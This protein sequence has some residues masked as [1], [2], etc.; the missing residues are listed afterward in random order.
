MSSSSVRCEFDDVLQLRNNP[1]V[2]LST[3]TQKKV[4]VGVRFELAILIDPSLGFPQGNAI[5]FFTTLA[6]FSRFTI[7]CRE[8]FLSAN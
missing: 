6:D 8:L 2:R 3:A 4:S 7:H 5:S 1:T